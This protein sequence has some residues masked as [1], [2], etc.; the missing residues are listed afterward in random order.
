MP[1]V[2]V[3]V[4]R[5][6]SPEDEKKVAPIMRRLYTFRNLGFN[7][8]TAAPAEPERV[9]HKVQ[10]LIDKSHVF[11]G[12]FTKK[13]PIYDAKASW[14][15]I[16]WG[17]LSGK[18]A[19][20]W[21]A[22]SWVIQESGYALKAIG[23]KSKL[24]IFIEK[25]VELPGLQG[26]LEYIEFEENDFETA[27]GKLNEMVNKLAADTIGIKVETV[28]SSTTPV[29]EVAEPI[30]T[31][32]KEPNLASEGFGDYWL[33][34]VSALKLRDLEI[35][36]LAYKEGLDYVQVHDPNLRVFWIAIYHQ[37]RCYAGQNEGLSALRTLAIE[38]PNDPDPLTAIGRC[39]EHF[40]EY[41][42]AFE[43]F[44]KAAELAA[45]DDKAINLVDAAS[46][47]SNANRSD[48]ALNLLLQACRNGQSEISLRKELFRLLKQDERFFEAF[49]IG[50]CT[51]RENPGDS[52]VRFSLAHDYA[53]QGLD[54]L[55]LFHYRILLE[56]D[57]KNGAYLNNLAVEYGRLG[58]P[59]LSVDSYKEAYKSGNSL[60]A[61]NLALL[62]LNAGFTSNAKE[63]I[64]DAMQRDESD[65]RLPATLAALDE[66]RRL[67]EAQEKTVVVD[68]E[69]HRKFMLALGEGFLANPV[70]LDGIWKLPDGEIRLSLNNGVLAGQVDVAIDTP[71]LLGA[72]DLGPP[73]DRRQQMRRI[74][75]SGQLAGRSCKF[76]MKTRT[77]STGSIA[78]LSTMLAYAEPEDEGYIAFSSDAQSGMVCIIKNK[79][80][81]EYYEISRIS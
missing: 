52:E 21:V 72:P 75:F 46:S 41:G 12:I 7:I 67:E 17:L 28:V 25:G 62:Y 5:S 3:F 57:F 23:G 73:Q 61:N 76:K 65:S 51:L 50:E 39:Y 9:S 74:N 30:V 59:I 71:I 11:V 78:P 37:H 29:V 66:H 45:G 33:K 47:L 19:T 34:M 31:Q 13:Y 44:L 77:I 26:D 38:N 32:P 24:I 6:F 42:N 10:D 53:E 63:L 43:Y 15:S 18:K 20:R 36:E 56:N 64:T 2:E 70:H 81:H 60:A 48:E 80:P 40:K 35:A 4:A 49:A 58:V 14:R 55:S 22:P 79:A 1:T 54:H 69:R 68:A 16:V 8:T 27:F